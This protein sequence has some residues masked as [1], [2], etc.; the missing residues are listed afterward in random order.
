MV[1]KRLKMQRGLVLSTTLLVLS[2]A[3]PGCAKK[4]C[5]TDSD[6]KGDDTACI[7]GKCV[8]ISKRSGPTVQTAPAPERPPEP[9]PATTYKVPF[10]PKK[11]P[12]RGPKDALVTIVEFSDF[13][14]P[15]CSR[16]TKTVHELL[17]Q[18]P[19]DVRLVFM[20]VPLSF[21]KHAEPAAQ[22][23]V[24]VFKEKGDAAFWKYHDLLFSHQH[25]LDT[26]SLVSFAKQV[27]A[28]PK[29][30]RKAI[31]EHVH[32]DAIAQQQALGKKLGVNG[33]PAFF[34]N[35]R[36]LVGA[37]P[38]GKFKR[39]I[40][41]VLGQAKKLTATKKLTPEKVYEEIMKT[42]KPSV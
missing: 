18:Y 40:E 30:V 14:C 22:A 17:R 10:D 26:D 23:A 25:S 16:A 31:T 15:F 1:H 8:D 7:Q 35:G 41:E 39:L 3:L 9:N 5:K 42:A 21:H 34:I 11:N 36:P 29:K 24:E 12:V 32:K 37:Q 4:T 13:Q 20:H 27:G 19:K 6:C 38:L 28:D 2:V 33:T